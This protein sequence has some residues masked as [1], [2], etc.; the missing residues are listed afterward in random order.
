MGPGSFVPIAGKAKP[1]LKGEKFTMK[2]P[3]LIYLFT[4]N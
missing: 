3:D 1:W 2:K 4:L